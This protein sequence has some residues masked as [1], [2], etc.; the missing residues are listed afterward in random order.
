ML[1]KACEKQAVSQAARIQFRGFADLPFVRLQ[2]WLNI[3]LHFGF[4]RLIKQ[5]GLNQW[6]WG[7][8]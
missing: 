8:G 3:E 7:W 2:S 4:C 5:S 6:P 1:A